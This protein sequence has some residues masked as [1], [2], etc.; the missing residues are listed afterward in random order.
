M[1]S[2]LP[3]G[4]EPVNNHGPD[5]MPWVSLE[6][7]PVKM[8]SVLV[9]TLSVKKPPARAALVGPW[10]K[11]PLVAGEPASAKIWS[12][13]CAVAAVTL[14]SSSTGAAGLMLSVRRSSSCSNRGRQPAGCRDRAAPPRSLWP[15]AD[16]KFR[17]Q[18]F[19]DMVSLPFQ[20]GP[21]CHG[22]AVAA[23]AQ[24]E[25]RG[26]AGPVRGLAA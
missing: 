1:M 20:I 13:S 21:R 2:F 24:T 17:S 18:L 15:Q 11:E 12:Q 25:R 16:F 4:L 7:P 23:G 19:R 5:W 26:V 9:L 14:P 22:T 6:P 10:E 3:C 8:S